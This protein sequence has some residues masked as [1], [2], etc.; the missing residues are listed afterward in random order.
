MEIRHLVVA[1]LLVFAPVRFAHAQDLRAIDTY[2]SEEMARQKI[3]G[4]AVAIVRNGS[5]IKAQGYGEANVEHR[6]AVT[7]DTIFQSG[8]LGKQFTAAALMLLVESGKVI[9]TDP[10][11]KHFPDAPPH[12]SGLE[13]RHLLTHTSGLPD[14]T[15]DTL[16]YRRDYTEEE[17]LRFAYALHPQFEPGARWSYSNTAYVV[18]GILIHKISGQF[19]G[20][21]LRERVFA[22]LG[23]TSASIISEEAIVPHRAAGYR[24]VNGELKNQEWVAPKLNTT[25]D[26]SLYLSL[27]DLVA[28][29]KGLREKK[30]LKAESWSRVFTPVTLNSGNPYPYGFGWGL[31]PIGSHRAQRHGGSWQGFQTFIARYPDDDLTI[32]VL[33]NLAQANPERIADGIGMRLDSTLKRFALKPIAESDPTED[34]RVRRLLSEAAAGTLAPEE[35]ALMRAG[36]FPNAAK[37][38]SDMLTAAGAVE[39][40]TLLDRRQLGDDRSYTYDVMLQKETLRLT[41]AVAPDGGISAFGLRPANEER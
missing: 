16:D 1:A 10:L 8:S 24:L 32:I 11:T 25:A 26:G 20:D 31:D 23:M 14:Y 21:L 41:M 28:W 34:A 6:V 36:F 22:P 27:R 29:D 15:D 38:Y 37:R 30:I 40:L 12:W 7:T 3:P 18:L 19:Y 39:R 35:F 33:T 9:L 17:L 2:V 5:A 4:I 13:V